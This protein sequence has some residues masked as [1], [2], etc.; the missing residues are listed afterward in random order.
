MEPSWIHSYLRGEAARLN[1]GLADDARDPRR[2]GACGDEEADKF[3]RLGFKAMPNG[4]TVR[5]GYATGV[6]PDVAAD[7]DF[8]YECAT[9]R[10]TFLTAV[11]LSDHLL[12]AHGERRHASLIKPKTA[13]RLSEQFDEGEG[14]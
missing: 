14:D 4:A 7:R 2:S 10:Q 1:G 9:C 5:D 12:R 11:Q 6:R 13:T 8:P 3:H